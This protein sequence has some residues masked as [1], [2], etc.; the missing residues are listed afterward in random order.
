MTIFTA[1]VLTLLVI[2]A[3]FAAAHLVTWADNRIRAW[4][5]ERDL[6]NRD[7]EPPFAF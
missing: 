4:R 7:D 2:C 1:S 3:A 6:N 5:N